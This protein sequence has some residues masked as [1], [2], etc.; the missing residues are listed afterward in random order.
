M[1]FTPIINAHLPKNARWAM[2]ISEL[3]LAAIVVAVTVVLY[4]I[5]DHFRAHLP[6]VLFTVLYVVAGLAVLYQ[7]A[8]LVLE[9]TV[10]YHYY[11][12]T[13]AEDRIAVDAGAIH[14]SHEV[15]PIRRLQKV[16]WNAGPIDRAL[17]LASLEIYSAGSS[18]TIH[19]LALDEAEA[20]AETLKDRINQ[21]IVAEAS[22]E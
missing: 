15:L 6:P 4:L 12:Y 10:G 21:L 1:T 9:P 16:E 8:A 7:L 20:L 13:I 22:H 17:G 19:N 5:L 2:A 18:L 14:R 11:R 3:I